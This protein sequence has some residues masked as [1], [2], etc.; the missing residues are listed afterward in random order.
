MLIDF[1]HISYRMLRSI[2]P[3]FRVLFPNEVVRADDLARVMVEV[4]VNGGSEARGP[5]LENRDI[6]AM[7]AKI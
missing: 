5:I 6:R 2:Y 4:A 7:V 3:A 1:A